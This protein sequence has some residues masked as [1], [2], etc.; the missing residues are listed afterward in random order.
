MLSK[1]PPPAWKLKL[2]S[3][4]KLEVI[5][6]VYSFQNSTAINIPGI[7]MR[8][9]KEVEEDSST[10]LL[11]INTGKDSP[12]LAFLQVD[13]ENN[14]KLVEEAKK[15]DDLLRFNTLSEHIIVELQLPTDV[16]SAKF[17]DQRDLTDWGVRVD[18]NSKIVV[19][20]PISEFSKDRFKTTE[21]KIL[22]TP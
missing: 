5:E 2:E 16:K 6:R 21:V 20:L 10:Y 18:P 3:S 14:L 13:L 22:F 8:V 19:K 12:L 11:Y 17:T 7:G 9:F 15:R 1:Q 4:N